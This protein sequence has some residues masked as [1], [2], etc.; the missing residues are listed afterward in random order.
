LKDEGG[1][2]KDEGK[3]NQE[4]GHIEAPMTDKPHDL[5]PTCQTLLRLARY[6]EGAEV[7]LKQVSALMPAGRPRM[8]LDH[9]RMD[10]TQIVEAVKG[11]L[12]QDNCRGKHEG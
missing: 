2:M 6:L 10:L 7:R 1:R 5:C 3:K 12:D 11:D 8:M 4:P 9:V